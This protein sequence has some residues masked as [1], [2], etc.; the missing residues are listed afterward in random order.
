MST[1]PEHTSS[2]LAT[3]DIIR[4][5]NLAPHSF[6]LVKTIRDILRPS[7][8]SLCFV[9]K[10]TQTCVVKPFFNLFW[11]CYSHFTDIILW[12]SPTVSFKSI[13]CQMIFGRLHCGFLTALNIVMSLDH[14]PGGLQVFAVRVHQLISVLKI[15]FLPDLRAKWIQ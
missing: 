11:D 15:I 14:M 4:L 10:L 8:S 6:Y 2:L 9:L 13:I 7:H 1:V 12:S 3:L 5:Q